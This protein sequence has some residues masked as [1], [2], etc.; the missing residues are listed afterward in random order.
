[1]K[2][3]DDEEYESENKEE[4]IIEEENKEN[5]I[6][7]IKE[8]VSD[9][10]I[11][12]NKEEEKEEKEEKEKKEK[13][14]NSKEE[15]EIYID[16]TS[17]ENG[18]TIYYIKGNFINNKKGIIRRY[19]DFHLLHSKLVQNWPCIFIP[20]IAEKKFFGSLEKKVINERIYQLENFL[21]ESIKN[22]YLINC[23][24][25]KLF[26]NENIINSDS[27]QS[28]SKKLKPYNLKQISENYT[29]YFTEYKNKN[30]QDFT[31]EQINTCI[32][33]INSFIQKLNKYKDQIV[34]IGEV[35][36]TK[37]YR[38][39]KITNNFTEFEK[40]SMMDFVNNDLSSLFFF[41][42]SSS[43][44][45]NENKYKKL[46]NNPYLLLSSWLR[47]KE[48]ELNSIKN[49]LNE[50]KSLLNK[51]ISFENKQKDITQ[52]I[53]DLE[54]G[55]KSFFDKIMSKD[56][57]KLKEKYKNELENQ[58]NEVIY[59]NNIINISKDYLSI[60]VYK[61]FDYLKI[62]FYDVVKKFA[63]IQKENYTLASDLWLKVKNK[64]NENNE[65]NDINDIFDIIDDNVKL[66]K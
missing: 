4:N 34:E 7:E 13:E 3:N 1:M 10:L 41:N 9:N 27:F 11:K 18:K 33:F 43:F 42:G 49:N 62:G 24:E 37:I 39:S 55:K 59:I 51:K 26:L 5:N 36:K 23:E 30:K 45:E 53:K 63:S 22:E 8:I 48:L 56:E 28:E 14:I 47:L 29:K 57:S 54:E 40:Y 32:N 35:K 2:E 66:E 15:S 60:E 25:L 52:K 50:Y 19:R 16:K 58:N 64:K 46:I 61:Y 31:D 38:E 6:E 65:Y 17:E 44:F 21:K 20:P 12:S